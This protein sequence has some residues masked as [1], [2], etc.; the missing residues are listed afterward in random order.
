MA[1]PKYRI[2]L[3]GNQING[4]NVTGMGA[5][6]K[7][8]LE[9]LAPVV[10]NCSWF[11]ASVDA[12]GYPQAELNETTTP[13]EIGNNAKFIAKISDDIQFIWGVF[14]AVPKQKLPPQWSHEY[15]GDAE[16]FDDI[17]AAVV[18]VRVFDSSYFEIYAIS[19]NY[20][21]PLKNKFKAEI[22]TLVEV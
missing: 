2:E 19:E 21:I 16:M 1:K 18:Q 8:I 17:D 15:Y 7:L 3:D 4:D 11:W 22:Q 12:F 6:I 20:L 14:L 13:T 10:T 5:Q 9:T